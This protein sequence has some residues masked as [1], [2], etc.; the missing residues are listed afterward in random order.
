MDT[1]GGNEKWLDS[2]SILKVEST[3]FVKDWIWSG[4]RKEACRMSPRLLT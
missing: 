4:R 1:W 2:G 3:G